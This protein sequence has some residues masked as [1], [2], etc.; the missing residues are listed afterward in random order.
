MYAAAASVG[1]AGVVGFAAAPRIGGGFID[2]RS[3]AVSR[4]GHTVVV[5]ACLLAALSICV[6]SGPVWP[7]QIAFEVPVNGQYDIAVVNPDGTGWA[8]LTNTP[9]RAELMPRWSPDGREVLF[10][11]ESDLYVMN[12]DGSNVRQITNTP[13]VTEGAADWSPEGSRIVFARNTGPGPMLYLIDADGGNLTQLTSTL[14]D[15]YPR[16]NPDGSEILFVRSLT[17]G[18]SISHWRLHTINID[19]TGLTPL[20]NHDA[21]DQTSAYSRDGDQIVWHSSRGGNWWRDQLWTMSANGAGQT[22]ITVPPYR[23]GPPSFSPDGSSI[24]CSRAPYNTWHNDL[25]IM[26]ADGGNPVQLTNT[27]GIYEGHPEWS[28]FLVPEP[29]SITLLAASAL[30][31]MRRRRASRRRQ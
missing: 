19:G 27:P 24:V 4:P 14:G 6:H 15:H 30:W 21:D 22:Q 13:G 31:L 3:E 11:A 18:Q 9:S 2:R 25:W 1:A 16:W 26:D 7:T 20:T 23:Y 29:A 8:N 17:W 10:M 5:S 28:P 12:A